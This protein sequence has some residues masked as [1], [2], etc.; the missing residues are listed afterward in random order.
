MFVWRLIDKM[1]KITRIGI[2]TIVIGASLLLVTILRSTFPDTT[3]SFGGPNT[4]PRRWDLYQDIRFPPRSLRMEVNSNVTSDAYILDQTGINLWTSN[5][6][7]NPVL[8]LTDV[9]QG[10]LTTQINERGAYGILINN[11]SNETGT[12][13]VIVT[14][15]G[16]EKDL[17]HGSI[18]TMII[19]I[20]ILIAISIVR[21]SKK[22]NRTP[23]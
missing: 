3:I 17:V 12:V 19:G 7:I 16:L 9:K 14:L 8:S 1:N 2:L 15:Y 18:V 4:S 10:S 23:I 5:G 6:T 22:M 20:A 21:A 11:V 13:K